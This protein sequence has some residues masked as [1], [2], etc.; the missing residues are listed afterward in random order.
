MKISWYKIQKKDDRFIVYR[1]FFF[2]WWITEKRFFSK[3]LAED[4]IY[5]CE[6]N[7]YIK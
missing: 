5:Y 6:L 3:E 2:F 4:Y 7:D 1:R